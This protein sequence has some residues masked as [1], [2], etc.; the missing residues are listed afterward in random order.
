MY[1]LIPSCTK[2]NKLALFCVYLVNIFPAIL[3]ALC[4]SLCVE[5]GRQIKVQEPEQLAGAISTTSCKAHN[6]KSYCYA[7]DSLRY[8]HRH[9]DNR[10]VHLLYQRVTW[11]SQ[12]AS[13]TFDVRCCH[14]YPIQSPD[15]RVL[16]K[17]ERTVYIGSRSDQP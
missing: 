9:V 12:G 1:L 15:Y 4:L 5:R 10:R 17:A 7:F 16:R 14:V 8:C 11:R 3:A 13:A 6:L 2:W